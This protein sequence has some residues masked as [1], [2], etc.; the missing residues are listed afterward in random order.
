MENEE[1]KIREELVRFILAND[2]TLTPQEL[3][4]YSIAALTII[5]TALEIKLNYK[6][7]EDS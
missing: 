7:S 4:R 2:S 3:D 5:K 1:Q 6:A